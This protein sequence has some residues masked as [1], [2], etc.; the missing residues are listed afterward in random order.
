M[1]DRAHTGPHTGIDWKAWL[2]PPVVFPFFLVVMIIAY[3]IFRT[4]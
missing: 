3:A 2:V 1:A 4:P